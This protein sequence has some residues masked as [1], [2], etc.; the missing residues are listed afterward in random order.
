MNDNYIKINKTRYCEL[1][2]ALSWCIKAEENGYYDGEGFLNNAKIL[3]I[4]MNDLLYNEVTLD[5]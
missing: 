3:L 1:I 4:D 2:N 5:E